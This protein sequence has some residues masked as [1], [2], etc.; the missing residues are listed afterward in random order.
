MSR[1]GILLMAHDQSRPLP[2]LLQPVCLAKSLISGRDI[3]VMSR[4]LFFSVPS[5]F[6]SR[7]KF[8][9]ATSWSSYSSSVCA[10]TS[11][12]GCDHMVFLFF[13]RL[14]N[15]FPGREI[16]VMSRHLFFSVPSV[17]MSRPKF[18]VATSW[19]SYSSS[20]CAATSVL[21]CDHMVFLFFQRL[22]NYFPGRE[23]KVMSRHPFLLL[24]SSLGHD[25]NEWLRH[26]FSC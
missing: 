23:I 25:L 14:S 6:M 11:V 13:Q 15:Y 1:H 4:H 24:S 2:F 18:D 5:V 21:G 20:V 12:L 19:S 22:S 7:P 3:E 8:D 10:A 9:V 17:F 16:K 26:H